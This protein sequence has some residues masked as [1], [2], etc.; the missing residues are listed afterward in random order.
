MFP[1]QGK[2]KAYLKWEHKRFFKTKIFLLPANQQGKVKHLRRT[3][4]KEHEQASHI[5]T[6]KIANEH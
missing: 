1:G 2:E 3:M 4:G 6:L 5:H